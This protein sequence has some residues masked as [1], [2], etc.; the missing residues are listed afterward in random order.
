MSV[1]S[2]MTFDGENIA[3]GVQLPARES[4]ILSLAARGLTD[5]QISAELGISRDTV[6]TYWRRILLRYKAAN[7]TEVVARAIEHE[8]RQR[9]QAAERKH[10]TLQAA[11]DERSEAFDRLDILLNSFDSAVIAVE[12]DGMIGYANDLFC[13][14]LAR[15][16]A[17]NQVVGRIGRELMMELLDDYADPEGH[18]QRVN[19]IVAAKQIVKDD[20]VVMKDGRRFLRHY[21]PMWRGNEYMGHIWKFHPYRDAS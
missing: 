16:M 5:K 2:Y 11:M 13:R 3:P 14:E 6:S 19:E 9:L 8:M 10:A 21:Y 18:L 15:G 1:G 17:A 4:E 20:V 7:R 12:E